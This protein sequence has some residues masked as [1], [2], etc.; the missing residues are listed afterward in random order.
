MKLHPYL[1]AQRGEIM[2]VSR[3]AIGVLAGIAGIA[4]VGCQ[5][6]RQPLAPTRSV[7]PSSSARRR[8][9]GTQRSNRRR[10]SPGRLL[11]SAGNGN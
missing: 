9:L 6:A 2:S 5:D 11:T 4:M 10:T 1:T 8:G 3:I 7:G